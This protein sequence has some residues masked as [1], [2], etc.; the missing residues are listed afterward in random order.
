MRRFIASFFCECGEVRLAQRNFAKLEMSFDEGK[1][2]A[3]RK[4]WV[5]N[6]SE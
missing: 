2:V 4:K 5:V 3:Q 1:L 6:S